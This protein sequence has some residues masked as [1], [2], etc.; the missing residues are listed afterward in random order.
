MSSTISHR[1]SVER[2]N[3]E[4][5][6]MMREAEFREKRAIHLCELKPSNKFF[7][8]AERVGIDQTSA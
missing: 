1:E 4:F 6:A 3:L 2:L 5:A 7:A 8:A